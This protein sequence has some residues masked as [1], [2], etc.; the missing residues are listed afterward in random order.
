MGLGPFF[1]PYYWEDIV[2]DPFES[3]W[4][5]DVRRRGVEDSTEPEAA[6]KVLQEDVEHSQASRHQVLAEIKTVFN[7]KSD[8]LVSFYDAFLHEG[9]IYL[10]LEY[11][12]CGSV[13]TLF[14]MARA[15]SARLPEEVL[16]NLRFLNSLRPDTLLMS[17]HPDGPD[18]ISG[19]VDIEAPHAFLTTWGVSGPFQEG[20]VISMFTRE[21]AVLKSEL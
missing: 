12:D 8:H 2:L 18:E 7:A 21:D 14:D 6:V 17:D 3:P 9:S 13:E 16:A 20:Q 11:M 1:G 5:P 4:R 15:A 10:A 19:K